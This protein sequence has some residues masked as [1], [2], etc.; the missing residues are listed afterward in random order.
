MMASVISPKA[1]RP[2]YRRPAHAKGRGYAL[3]CGVA[4][5]KQPASMFDLSRSQLRL[6]PALATGIYHHLVHSVPF[7]T[8]HGRGYGPAMHKLL[9]A[10]RRDNQ[11]WRTEPAAL[12]GGEGSYGNGSAMRVAPLGAYFA[13]D[14]QKIV[15]Q[16]AENQRSWFPVALH[17]LSTSVPVACVGPR[18]QADK[19][20]KAITHGEV[21]GPKAGSPAVTI[22][23]WMDS[24][25]LGMRPSTEIDY[26]SQL[27][28]IRFLADR[29]Q[30][31]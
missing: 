23:K 12:F 21:V 9:A 25:P 8:W 11:A 5:P 26:G 17:R 19:R 27:V 30:R 24:Y 4:I 7:R 14:V 2:V 10:I 18:S 3:Y 29:Q 20:W 13:D 22:G 16:S 15:E 1:K 28:G 6:G 31:V